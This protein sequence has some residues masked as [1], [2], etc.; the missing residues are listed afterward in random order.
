MDK[1]KRIFLLKG[2]PE[3]GKTT[4]ITRTIDLVRT[5]GYVVGGVISREKRSEGQREGFELMDLATENRG[6]LAS[7]KLKTGPRV[8]RYRVNL[9]DIA[10]V[11]AK[12][13]EY[14]TKNSDLI[15]CDEIGPMEILSPEFKRAIKSSLESGKPFLGVVHMGIKDSLLDFLKSSPLVDIFEVI[16]ENRSQLPRLISHKIISILESR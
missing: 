9:I 7:V 1:L 11:G 15:V 3:I 16:G 5:E 14:A 4:V 6:I 10:E 2:E 13:L 8:G 12:S